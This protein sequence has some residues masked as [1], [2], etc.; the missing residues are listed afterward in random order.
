M[1]CIECSYLS[2]YRS[3]YMYIC[4]HTYSWARQSNNIFFVSVHP[5]LNL[6]LLPLPPGNHKFIFFFFPL[7]Y[8]AAAV[9]KSLQSC[10][11]LCNPRVQ[12]IHNLGIDIYTLL[13]VK[14][15]YIL[16]MGTMWEPG[17]KQRKLS[18]GLQVMTQKGRMGGVGGRLQREG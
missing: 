12:L 11:T 13:C 2:K 17:V 3:K 14:H 16:H 1:A 15:S 4:K 8:A 6:S 9:A 7:G 10:P 5:S 18:S